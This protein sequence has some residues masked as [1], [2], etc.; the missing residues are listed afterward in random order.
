M[1]GG[2]EIF[3]RMNV[4]WN[5][6]RNIKIFPEK[7]QE[8]TF[9]F[10]KTQARNSGTD[11]QPLRKRRVIVTL[12]ATMKTMY[13]LKNRYYKAREKNMSLSSENA[14][15]ETRAGMINSC[16]F[17]MGIIKMFHS[18]MLEKKR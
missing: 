5:N 6:E 2:L 14:K 9:T 7:Y 13:I 4:T 3:I 16:F 1:Q 18:Y 10:M 8:S 11:L 17:F 15:N 12:A